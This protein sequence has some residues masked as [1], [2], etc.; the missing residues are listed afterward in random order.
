MHHCNLLEVSPC[1]WSDFLLQGTE[2]GKTATHQTLTSKEFYT[3][4]TRSSALWIKLCLLDKN[5]F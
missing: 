4:Q 1:L 3:K 2:N 5:Q